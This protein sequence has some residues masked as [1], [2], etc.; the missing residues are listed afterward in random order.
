MNVLKLLCFFK[1]IKNKNLENK[2][3]GIRL[4][5]WL[6]EMDLSYIWEFCFHWGIVHMFDNLLIPLPG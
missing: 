6:G 5:F 2:G 3:R 1:K 4:R